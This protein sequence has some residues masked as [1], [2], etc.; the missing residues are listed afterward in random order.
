MFQGCEA[1]D[2]YDN[3]SDGTANPLFK[4]DYYNKCSLKYIFV[5][6]ANPFRS[7]PKRQF[8]TPVLKV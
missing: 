8:G 4:G 6:I 5:C 1:S 2:G 7:F 3:H